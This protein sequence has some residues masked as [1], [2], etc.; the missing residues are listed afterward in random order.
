MCKK[1]IYFVSFVFVLAVTGTASA[2]LLDIPVTNAGFEDPV[3]AADDWTWIDVP[4]WTSVGGEAPGVW[5]VT[6]ADLVAPEGQNVLYTENAVGDGAVVAQVLTETFAANTSYT[7]TVDVGNS[8]YYYFAG[9]SVQLLVDGTVI[10]EDNDTLWPDYMTWATSTVQY[11]YDSADEALVG[12][13]LE[14]RLL[15]LGLDKDSPPDNTVGVEFD[16][17]KLSSEKGSTLVAYWPLDDDAN[18]TIGELNWTLDPNNGTSIS[19]DSMVGTGALRFDGILGEGRQDA[20]GPLIDAF[21]TKTVMFWIK[22]DSTSGIQALYDEGG[23][24]NGL[25]IRINEGTLQTA[26]RDASDQYTITIPF[27]STEW[28][29]IAVSY[30]NGLLLLL[31]DGAQKATVMADFEVNEVSSH[32]NNSTIGATNQDAFGNNTTEPSDHFA[33]LMDDIR[34]YD[35]ALPV[36]I[37]SVPTPA[38][39]AVLSSTPV[40]LFWT[41]GPSAVSQDLYFGESFDDVDAG[42]EST[43]LGLGQ[44]AAGVDAPITVEDLVAETTYYWRI[45][46][47]D[48]AGPV[49]GQIWSFTLAPQ[50]ATNPS[51]TDGAMFIKPT[52]SLSWSRGLNA[53]SHTVY[54]GDNLDD[55]SNATGGTAQS[56]TTYTP[57]ATL[58]TG[59]VY[60]WR[61]D[62]Y[63]GTNTH[64][65]DIWSFETPPFTEITD[66]S[67]VGWWK[68]DGEYLDLGYVF[69]NSGY[70]NHGTLRGDP[71]LVEGS[72]GSALEFD[73]DGDYVNIDGYKGINADRTD[74]NNPFN[75]A[76]SVACW[77]KTTGDAGALVT[78]G[79]SDGTGVGGQYQSFR[80]NAGRLRAEH[81]NGNLQSDTSVNDGEWHHVAQVSVEGANLRVPNTIL[82][83][84]GMEDATRGG[85]DNIFN[86][87]ED[88]DVGI[89]LRASHVDRFFTGLFDDVRVYDKVLTANEIKVL[90]GLLE[91]SNPDPADGAKIVDS[92]AI[93]T[94]SPGPFGAEFDVYFGTNP[95]PGAAELV[96]RVGAATHIATDL[97]QGQTYYWRVDDV[98]AD[99][100]TIHTGNV[101]SL[102][103]PPKGAYNQNPADGQEVTDIDADLNWDVDWSPVMSVVHFGTDADQV[104]N[105][106]EG[107]G[108]PLMEPGFDPGPLE[109]GTTY[110]WRVDVFYGT[111]VKGDV[112]SFTVP[113]PVE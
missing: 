104:T 77:I 58:E 103:V 48:E 49:K 99:G 19:T 94:W 113:A 89:G 14:I 9:Y 52:T 66:P 71:Q 7:L 105:A 65:G 25:A 53:E 27:D 110:Y 75:P 11:T 81:G 5:H 38:D 88:A 43:L 15:N 62:E 50:T 61:I 10:A 1:L 90:A 36:R 41:P 102:W 37:A 95:D 56:E 16:N 74:P 31:V 87:T 57:E 79:S 51:P 111:W 63:D 44:T 86:I 106:P 72:D 18:D 3:L 54:I 39:G 30:D 55:V 12:Q 60:Y 35:G 73:G 6:S 85:S 69:D 22:A 20:V 13:P 78:W 33:G 80:I 8:N 76:F 23:S 70:N 4:G 82:Y 17:V 21:T 108:P 100:T 26:V 68:L 29:E 107:F 42:A 59:T 101:W 40:D 98:E 67:L 2:A 93:L 96:G 91:S 84:D 28:T 64:K 83:I 32:S 92:L 47:V 109:P 46:T 24:T 112:L 34:L 45:D 97:A